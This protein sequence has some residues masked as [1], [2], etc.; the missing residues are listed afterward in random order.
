[1]KTVKNILFLL[2]LIVGGNAVAQVIRPMTIRYNNPSVRGNIVYV[3][4]SIVST[5]GVGSGTPGTG[6]V[7][8]AGTS[9]NNA[10]G[11]INIDDDGPVPIPP[12]TIFNY[13][14]NW[15]YNDINV[16]PVNNP[17]GSN[18]TATTYVETAG[19]GWNTIGGNGPLGYNDGAA[20]TI[21]NTGNVNSRTPTIYFRKVVAIPSVAAYT[22]FTINVRRDDGVAVYV[23]G[24]LVSPTAPTTV[25]NLPA[26]WVHTTL[27]TDDL[28]EGGDEYI[29]FNVPIANFVNGNNT[30]AV[31]VH[32]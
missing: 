14:S 2:L 29:S 31:E 11:G 8:P 9:R 10:G 24:V 20:V 6:E 17:V 1:M 7:P 28:I 15:H 32:N 21:V 16:L 23:N 5:Q 25:M 3:A 4:N 26:T 12:V 18:W 27:A 13:G 19:N 22:S 30:I